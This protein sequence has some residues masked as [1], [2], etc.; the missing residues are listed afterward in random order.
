MPVTARFTFR[1]KPG[2]KVWVQALTHNHEGIGPGFADSEVLD[3][4]RVSVVPFEGAYEATIDPRELGV[5]YTQGRVVDIMECDLTPK[6]NIPAFVLASI[7]RAI[8]E[9]RTVE[10]EPVA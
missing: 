5:A 4:Y 10:V 8:T 1:D 9:G 2:L 6:G 7:T 3:G